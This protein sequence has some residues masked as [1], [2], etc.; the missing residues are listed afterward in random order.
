MT[1]KHYI[2][3]ASLFAERLGADYPQTE[4]RTAVLKDVA[5]RLCVIFKEDNPAF[6][7]A[8]FMTACGF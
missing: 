1:K 2:K 3:I 6:D 5:N 7:K 8:R 4:L